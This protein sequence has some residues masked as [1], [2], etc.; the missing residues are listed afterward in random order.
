MFQAGEY[1]YYASSGLCR[2]E[3]VALLNLSGTDR[4]AFVLSSHSDGGAGRCDLHAG[5]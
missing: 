2:V 3:E 1:I 5:G 4:G